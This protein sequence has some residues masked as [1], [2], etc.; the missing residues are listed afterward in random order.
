ML[1][2]AK[3][4]KAESGTIVLVRGADRGAGRGA[5][6]AGIGE[7]IVGLVARR[8]A[9]RSGGRRAAL[10]SLPGGALAVTVPAIAL[11]ACVPL[12]APPAVLT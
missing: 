3:W 11:V 6:A 1:P 12:T 9:Q 10:A 7:R 5:A 8:V 4:A 2:G